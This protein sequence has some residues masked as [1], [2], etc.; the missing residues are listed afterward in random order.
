MVAGHVANIG[1]QYIQPAAVLT[2]VLAGERP[3]GA[4]EAAREREVVMAIH[5]ET[6]GQVRFRTRSEGMGS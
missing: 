1:C 3:M 5:F 4:A 6:R 2:A